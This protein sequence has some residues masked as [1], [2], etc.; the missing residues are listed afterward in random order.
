M[1]ITVQILSLLL[2][3]LFFNQSFATVPSVYYTYDDAGNRTGRLIIT[4]EDGPSRAGRKDGGNSDT[5]EVQNPDV[6]AEKNDLA[7]EQKISEQLQN[8]DVKIYPNPTAGILYVKTNSNSTPLNYV[9]IGSNGETLLDGQIS[10]QSA[11][12]DISRYARSVYYLTLF[13]GAEKRVWKII[14]Q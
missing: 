14:K 4:E 5:T 6:Q 12:L 13:N 8:A 2:F 7:V 11:V 9:L 10:N 3:L 1:R